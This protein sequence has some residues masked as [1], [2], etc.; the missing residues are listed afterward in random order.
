M[1]STLHLSQ[2][3]NSR[4]KQH[5]VPQKILELFIYGLRSQNIVKRQLFAR[6][7]FSV[8]IFSIIPQSRFVGV[9]LGDF[10]EDLVDCGWRDGGWSRQS[11]L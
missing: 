5:F 4:D 7:F 11:G 8:A 1:S 9:F 6:Y 2:P 10:L 3:C